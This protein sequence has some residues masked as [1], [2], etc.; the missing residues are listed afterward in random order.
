MEMFGLV[1]ARLLD[2]RLVVSRFVSRL[3]DVIRRA[4]LWHDTNGLQHINCSDSIPRSSN[5]PIHESGNSSGGKKRKG[6]K[7][8][9]G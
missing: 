6:R 3:M 5:K 7:E 1:T 4:A 8:S 2:V 9:F